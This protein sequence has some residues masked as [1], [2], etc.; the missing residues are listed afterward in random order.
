MVLDR[1]VS[2]SARD[3]A[4][5][6]TS[7]KEVRMLKGLVKLVGGIVAI[8]AGVFAAVAGTGIAGDGL[9][10]TFGGP[11]TDKGAEGLLSRKAS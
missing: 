5:R 8:G 6:K 10:E 11:D 4:V 2:F 1:G 3:V 7:D 9:A